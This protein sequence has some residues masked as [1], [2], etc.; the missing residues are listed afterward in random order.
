MKL[1]IDNCYKIFVFILIILA[2]TF[3]MMDTVLAD[4]KLNA[5]HAELNSDTQI[6]LKWT[7]VTNAVYY[8]VFRDNV[9]IAN[10][11]VDID[12]NYLTFEDTG[13]LPETSYTYEIIAAAP[14]GNTIESTYC[15]ASTL[16]MKAPSI[17]SSCLDINNNE[18]TLTWVNNSLATSGT[19]VQK[20]GEGPVAQISKAGTSISFV[21]PSLTPGIGSQYTIMSIDGKGHS[22]AH[23]T[24][25][26]ITPIDPPVIDASIKN[27]TVTI[28]WKRHD[29]IE[30][31]RL[32]RAKYLEKERKWGPWETINTNLSKNTLSTTDRPDSDGT[33]RYRLYIDNKKY[34]GY[35]NIS[36][37]LARLLAPL[38]LQCV[39]VGSGRIDLSWTN[40]NRGNFTLE[41][42]K[43]NNSGSYSTIA[44]LDSNITTYSDT[45][46]ILPNKYYY[47]RVTAHDES[48]NFASTPVYSIYTGPPSPASSLN[49]EISSLTKITL[50]WKDSSNNE[51]GFKVE[52]KV[53]SGG[54]VEIASLPANTTTYTDAGIIG[55][56]FYTYRVKPF[57][58]SGNA[59]SY[60][61]EVTCT[62]SAIKSPP[63]SLTITPASSTQI[64]LK[65]SY[66]SSANYRTVIERKTEDKNTW[67]IITTLAT[68]ITNYS[69]TD[70]FPNTRYFYRVK[71]YIDN[72]V[73]SK[74]Y[75]ETNGIGV[76]TH[77]EAPEDL[78]AAWTVSGLVKLTWDDESWGESEIIIERKTGNGRFINIGSQ[79]AD[80]SV[81]HDYDIESDT[82]YTYRIKAVN[83]FNSSDYSN[84]SSVDPTSFHPPQN[85][86]ATI[87][88][89]TKII[90]S[91]N[92]RNDN[93][94]GFRVEIKSSEAESWK[95]VASLSKNTTSYAMDNLKPDT[96][97]YFRVIAK[98]SSYSSE[99]YS[100]EIQVLMKSLSSP[101]H[102]MVKTTSP[103]QIVLEWKDNSDD[104]MG[105]I[106]ERKSN[107]GEFA[108]VA[109]VGRN[110]ERFAD[111][112]LYANTTYY[113][114]VKGYDKN[115]YTNWTNIGMAK[116]SPS[117]VF[118]DLNSVPWAKEAIES[119][120]GRGII[121]GKSE[122]LGIFAPNDRITR[123]EF[124]TL[125]VK[126]FQL[127]KTPIGTFSDVKPNHWYYNNVMIAKSMGI[128]TGTGNNYFYPNEP[129]K[130]ED[131]AVILAKTFKTVGK[132]LPNYSN[133]ILDIYNDKSHISIY[134]L[135]SMA[136]L[137][138]E[139]IINGKS[140]TQLSPRDYAT[141]AEAAVILYKALKK[142]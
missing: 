9:H 139:E 140:N 48:G 132:P 138:G 55:K 24:P 141:R 66:A 45:D 10:I 15:S 75:P 12:R 135:Q 59:S 142:F 74:P 123:A 128:I 26:T 95:R 129:I 70:L 136:I 92:D 6:N 65:W 18:V 56:S 5:T 34:S 109:R 125:I 131:I 43:R 106:I 35:S 120:A 68:G 31:F 77:L 20:V 134:A 44:V 78:K 117:V 99:A 85:L 111:N 11:D 47:Y 37:P 29:H 82:S 116:T 23:S 98:K 105:F 121:H 87:V 28:S 67:E 50:N 30:K 84:E 49:L 90:L 16:K 22:S 93:E 27:S 113:Y 57:N 83:D 110:V 62:T 53:G 97:Y 61:N 88:S 2:V 13:L 118:N 101:S 36:K 4:F 54:F 133:S 137:N 7:S 76:Y 58:S 51:S 63:G 21:D 126:A 25:I 122:E 130:R 79:E 19:I 89:N 46:Q 119:L 80:K 114:R 60:S 102:L 64:D 1:I 17:V 103:Y 91:W 52:R 104:E 14:G 73:F 72:R 100:E 3:A 42:E 115:T 127:D 81:W 69:D 32:E 94:S 96:L 107:N 33:Y 39:P 71:T 41:I 40:P 124:I 108:E 86:K 8:S 38:N 112:Q